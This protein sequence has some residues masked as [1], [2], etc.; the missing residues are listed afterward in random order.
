MTDAEKVKGSP[1]VKYKSKKN[2]PCCVC[3]WAR[4][5]HESERANDAEKVKDEQPEWMKPGY[6]ENRPWEERLEE[7]GEL[8]GDTCACMMEH[9]DE[10]NCEE[11]E[12]LKGF[13]KKELDKKD[14]HYQSKL[15]LMERMASLLKSALFNLRS[16]TT[17]EQWEALEADI[18]DALHKLDE[19]K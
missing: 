5:A 1:C 19:A 11:M 16:H 2:S 6:G 7:Y 3:G 15:A 18:E 4:L 17:E 9:P 12:E 13:I 14:S 10:C 8:H